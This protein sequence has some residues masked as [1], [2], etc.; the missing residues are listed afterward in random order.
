MLPADMRHENTGSKTVCSRRIDPL[1]D[2]SV[3]SGAGNLD[4]RVITNPTKLATHKQCTCSWSIGVQ[5]SAHQI[6]FIS[7]NGSRC[8]WGGVVVAE[9]GDLLFVGYCL[10]DEA[11]EVQPSWSRSDEVGSGKGRQDQE[12]EP[13][14]QK[15]K[16][17]I[18][19][20]GSKGDGLTQVPLSS[21]LQV[22]LLRR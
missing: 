4:E 19:P 3:G 5:T 8:L 9:Y 12:G 18:R 22:R 7:L 14:V 15:S 10:I 13:A 16:K 20:L 1:V 17:R 21:L 2:E 11:Q 6:L